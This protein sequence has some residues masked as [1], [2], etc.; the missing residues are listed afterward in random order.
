MQLKD[1][2][3]R[4]KAAF[5]RFWAELNRRQIAMQKTIALLEKMGGTTGAV[6]RNFSAAAWRALDERGELPRVK[7]NAG[8]AFTP[9]YV[10][11]DDGRGESIP[12]VCL[13]IPTGGGKTLLGAHIVASVGMTRGLVL[14]ITPS[15]AIF[16]QTFKNFNLRE[17]PY[18][19]ILERGCNGRVKLLR[20]DDAISRDDLDNYLCL[21]PIMLQ[22]ADRQ[23]GRDFLKIFRDSGKHPGVF[24]EPDDF[25]AN[26]KAIE[27]RPDLERN[28]LADGETPGS[29]KHSLLNLLKIERPL[30]V[31]DEAHNAYTPNR[32]QKLGAFNP[33]LVVELSATPQHGVSN[34]L[35]DI[36]GADLQA[37]EMIK[38]PIAVSNLD[39]ADWKRT[40]A[41][42][43]EKLSRLEAEAR[44]FEK[45]GGEYIRPLMLI[46]VER[47][48]KDQRDGERIHAED[49]RDC[50]I[51][52]LGAPAEQIR[53][54]TAERN[55]LA[56]EDLLSPY[57][58]VRYILTKNA[59][60]EGWDCPF[61]YV[62]VLLDNTTAKTAVTQMTGRILRQP[63]AR[64]TGVDALDSCYIFCFNQDVRKAAE[65]VKKGLESEGMG[66]LGEFI[67]TPGGED[68]AKKIEFN[69]RDQFRDLRVVLPKVSHI[70]AGKKRR[71]LDYDRDILSA[72]D[73]HKI[74]VAAARDE[75]IGALDKDETRLI[76][77][78]VDLSP[79]Q[80]PPAAAREERLLVD[81]TPTIEFFARRLS[82]TIP[83]PWLAAQIVDAVFARLR[84][85]GF[86]DD[87]IFD[88]RVHLSEQIKNAAARAIEKAARA[89]FAAKL[90]A[91]EIRFSLVA[92]RDGFELPP[93]FA[94]MTA[95]NEMPLLAAHGDPIKKSLFERTSAADFNNLEKDFAIYADGHAAVEWW[96]RMV[97]KNDYAL[98]GWRRSRMYPDFVVC[99]DKRGHGKRRVVVLETKGMH[100][101]GAA[102]TEYKRDLLAELEK[103]EPHAI[104]C[105]DL[106]LRGENGK[107]KMALRILFAKDYKA[108]FN[109]IVDETGEAGSGD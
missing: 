90:R 34:I 65:Q 37:A 104:E 45:Q 14:W 102:D 61:A 75:K 79:P 10:R 33:R 82:D 105:G 27:A 108:D 54:K 1:F 15:R 46:R 68:G 2:Q 51:K 76:T 96:H 99:V 39:K 63:R 94:R 64:R 22:A 77:R 41:E 60:R 52:E 25:D 56:D 53:R 24:P 87:D 62:L 29:V 72:L 31:L 28:L 100:L 12:H 21:M 97:A 50:L 32:R 103:A 18:R 55:E 47:V 92:D 107:R 26:E 42:A 48:G 5:E 69:R 78:L 83:N 85:D 44:E 101:Q 70:D 93:T 49:A 7:D 71:D 73:W 91:G 9:D 23:N 16:E 20:K 17:H 43:N 89:V 81:K 19:Q 8:R 4:A 36:P 67:T 57:S 106:E 98:Q 40:L 109:R 35:V 13:K 11:R 84:R 59:L 38:L 86:S 95:A 30:V 80:T 74:A 66:D 58:Q 6:D 88:C 3:E